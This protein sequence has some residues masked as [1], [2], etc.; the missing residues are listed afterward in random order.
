MAVV[1]RHPNLG[2]FFSVFKE[3][4][5]RRG[6]RK[7]VLHLTAGSLGYKKKK[8]RASLKAPIAK[9]CDNYRLANTV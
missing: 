6:R 2:F 4:R 7:E 8:E 9:A 1:I 5:L 3:S